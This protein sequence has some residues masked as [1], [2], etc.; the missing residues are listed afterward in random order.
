VDEDVC[1]GLA[2]ADWPDWQTVLQQR[3]ELVRDCVRAHLRLLRTQSAAL[4][5]LCR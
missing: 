5:A 3:L 1:A 2:P 4:Q